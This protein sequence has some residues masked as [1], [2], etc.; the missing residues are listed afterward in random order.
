MFNDS[1]YRFGAF[2]GAVALVLVLALTAMAFSALEPD[3]RASNARDV[4]LPNFQPTIIPTL[5]N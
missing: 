3:R 5:A 2:A 4:S 1:E